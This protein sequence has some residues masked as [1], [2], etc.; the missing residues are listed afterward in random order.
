MCCICTIADYL[1]DKENEGMK[2]AGQPSSEK[3]LEADGN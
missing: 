2:V 1:A 3:L